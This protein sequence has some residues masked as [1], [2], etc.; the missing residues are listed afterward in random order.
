M[1]TEAIKEE[2]L[3]LGEGGGGGRE[4]LSRCHNKGTNTFLSSEGKL[5][6]LPKS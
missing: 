4:D 5:E 1:I 2:H 6:L 3:T